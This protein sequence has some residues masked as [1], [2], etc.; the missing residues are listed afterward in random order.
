MISR[1]VFRPCL[2]RLLLVTGDLTLPSG[3][4]LMV[5]NISVHLVCIYIYIF[6]CFCHFFYVDF[7]FII[8]FQWRKTRTIHKN[9]KLCCSRNSLFFVVQLPGEDLKRLF[10]CTGQ[11]TYRDKKKLTKKNS[12]TRRCYEPLTFFLRFYFFLCRLCKKVSWSL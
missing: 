9:M 11:K 10:N 6:R 5:V 3:D 2:S 4:Y 8:S 7:F 1:F 12:S